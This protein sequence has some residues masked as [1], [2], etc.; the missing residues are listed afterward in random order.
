MPTILKTQVTLIA[1]L[2][3]TTGVPPACYNSRWRPRLSIGPVL[4]P[5]REE[6]LLVEDNKALRD[7]IVV[8]LMDDFE[9]IEADRGTDAL[10]LARSRDPHL[11][12]LDLELPGALDG[13]SVCGLL[14]DGRITRNIPVWILT[15]YGDSQ[16][17]EVAR[18]AGAQDY[19]VKPF[20]PRE[21]LGKIFD[22]LGE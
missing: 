12:I 1:H 5:I 2:M 6:S 20:S 14:K 13:I 16:F 4:C 18:S 22:L 9:T 15:G 7:I 11:I 17:E 8:T 21:L 3:F 19:I 10:K